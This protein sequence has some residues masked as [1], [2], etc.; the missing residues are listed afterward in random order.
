MKFRKLFDYHAIVTVFLSSG[1]IIFNIANTKR[2][3]SSQQSDISIQD[4][5]L[6]NKTRSFKI[7]GMERAGKHIQLTFVNEYDKSITGFQAY[8]GKRELR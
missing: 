8:M 4:I 7:S 5:K 6:T 1:I 2:K 3:S